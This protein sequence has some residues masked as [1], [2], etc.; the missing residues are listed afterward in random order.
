MT[1][2]YRS[3]RARFRLLFSGEG[4]KSNYFDKSIEYANTVSSIEDKARILKTIARGLVEIGKD[5]QANEIYR[6]AIQ[7]ATS[8]K[9]DNDRLN[10]LL[11]IVYDFAEFGY[12]NEALD[13][14][15]SV[16]EENLQVFRNM[17]LEKISVSFAKAG[18]FDKA[19]EIA[20]T[21]EKDKGKG[22]DLRVNA[23]LKIS[24]QIISP[25]LTQKQLSEFAKKIMVE[26]LNQP[27]PVAYTIQ[28]LQQ[29]IEAQPAPGSIP[30]IESF[31][32]DFAKGLERKDMQLIELVKTDGQ[33]RMED[34]VEVYRIF[35]SAT[36][37][38]LRQ[39]DFGPGSLSCSS[40][41]VFT[42]EGWV[43]LERTENGW[44][45]KDGNF[46]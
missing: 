36:C 7:L 16:S 19:L 18:Q 37:R 24:I 1:P 35:F 29:K 25:N 39:M 3:L 10:V 20:M 41:E 14:A 9:E 33:S 26:G 28:S 46:L 22:Y 45:P 15:N 32:D 27:M 4:A 31:R 40:G 6:Q 11:F 23:L 2:S 42:R 44:R 38:C 12:L 8:I 13:I 30:T 43:S 17:M 34:R 5:K 21:I